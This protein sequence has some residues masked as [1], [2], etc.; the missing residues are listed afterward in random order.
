MIVT[1]DTEAKWL[2]R[3]V[4]ELQRDGLPMEHCYTQEDFATWM[5]SYTN[6]FDLISVDCSNLDVR[7]AMAPDLANWC[8][9]DGVLVLDDW[10]MR[11]YG[12][13]MTEALRPFGFETHVVYESRDQYDGYVAIAERP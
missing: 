13:R 7:V 2:Q 8:A 10:H 6:R 4:E 12:Q 11:D 9:P 1:T 3:T 5:R